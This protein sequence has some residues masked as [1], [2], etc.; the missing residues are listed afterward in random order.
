MK[1]K[2]L[3]IVESFL[4]YCHFQYVGQTVDL[5]TKLVKNIMKANQFD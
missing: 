2:N 4:F 1:F 5:I 3:I